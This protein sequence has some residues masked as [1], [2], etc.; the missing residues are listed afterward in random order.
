MCEWRGWHYNV[1]WIWTWDMW[2]VWVAGVSMW[3]EYG[4]SES[5]VDTDRLM[6]WQQG[7]CVRDK[8]VKNQS[9]ALELLTEF[10][11]NFSMTK[12]GYGSLLLCT[13]CSPPTMTQSLRKYT[14]GPSLG[15]TGLSFSI[16]ISSDWVMT[17]PQFSNSYI[18]ISCHLLT[19]DRQLM[20]ILTMMM[21]MHKSMSNQSIS[22]SS[23][24][25]MKKPQFG[26]S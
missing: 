23:D 9:L 10:G 1:D 3:I 2:C 17:K 12:L 5:L 22:Q 7:Q 4:L 15:L 20:I 6:L 8:V 11:F 16:S 19:Y 24:W 26:N 18:F 21:R 25:L 13:N 14:S